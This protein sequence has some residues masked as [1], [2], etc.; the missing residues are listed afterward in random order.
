MLTTR[1]H[2]PLQGGFYPSMALPGP[3]G[4]CCSV[5]PGFLFQSSSSPTA[6]QQLFPG[7]WTCLARPVGSAPVWESE[8]HILSQ[9]VLL[10]DLGPVIAP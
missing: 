4:R 10:Y 2:C 7:A 3:E 9:A 1:G 5:S 6:G 8:G